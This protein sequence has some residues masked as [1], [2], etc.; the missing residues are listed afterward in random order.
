MLRIAQD[1]DADY[2]IFGSFNS[3][4]TNLTVES[5]LLRVDP[6][7]LLAPVSETGPLSSMMDMQGKLRRMNPKPGLVVVDYLQRMSCRGRVE[8]LERRKD[9]CRRTGAPCRRYRGCGR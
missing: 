3:D 5:H 2:V 6:P 7:A 4:G 9:L 1:L 8:N